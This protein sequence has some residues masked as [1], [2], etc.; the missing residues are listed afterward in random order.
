MEKEPILPYADRSLRLAFQKFW[1]AEDT[2]TA[3]NA[4]QWCTVVCAALMPFLL[5]LLQH[6]AVTYRKMSLSMVTFGWTKLGSLSEGLE[7]GCD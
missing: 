2:H 1:S 3:C 4:V 5:A 7:W 6:P